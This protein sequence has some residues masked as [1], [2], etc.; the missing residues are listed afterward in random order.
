M[1]RATFQKRWN[2]KQLL[3][4]CLFYVYLDSLPDLREPL[5]FIFFWPSGGVVTTNTMREK[6]LKHTKAC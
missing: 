4:Y 2:R 6:T 5:N 1:P 3:F